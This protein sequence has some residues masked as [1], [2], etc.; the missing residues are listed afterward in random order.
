MRNDRRFRGALVSVLFLAS[1]LP[2]GSGSAQHGE[3][4]TV[5]ATAIPVERIPISLR[6][7]WHF[8]AIPGV[9]PGS[10]LGGDLGG[11]PAPEIGT[12]SINPYIAV[13]G[14]DVV[15]EDASHRFC[16]NN[17][18]DDDRLGKS[19]GGT[20]TTRSDHTGVDIQANLGAPGTLDREAR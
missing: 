14:W 18:D 9:T 12:P 6:G 19:Y 8:A 5:T 17:F 7:T 15:A 1:L 11:S 13:T 10:S 16:S 2:G 3:T 20:N 4:I